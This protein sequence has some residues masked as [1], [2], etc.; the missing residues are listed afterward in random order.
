MGERA[1]FGDAGRLA[2][3]RVGTGA[4]RAGGRTSGCPAHDYRGTLR[5]RRHPAAVPRRTVPEVPAEPGL[6]VEDPASG[7]CG[8]VVAA[9]AREVTL[10]DRH[11]RRRVFPLLPAGVPGR[12]RRGHAG[13]ARAARPAAPARSASGSVA[14]GRAHGAHRAGGADL[15]GGPAR[16]RAGGAGVGPRPAGRGRRR[17]ADARHGRPGRRGRG[18]R[19]RAR[20][21][22]SGCWSTT[23]WPGRRSP[24]AAA[25]SPGPHVLVTGHPYVDVWQ[26]VKPSVVGIRAGRGCRAAPTGRPGS[27][28]RCAGASRPTGP[29]GCSARCAATATWRRR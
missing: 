2:G 16:R 17:G 27:A 29:A 10:E 26:A 28:P 19:A 20:G 23:S 4:P 3:V 5:R 22:G 15:G 24:A 21:G 7:F 13:A 11:G 18:V 9:D 14:G 25:A 6:V 1:T 12:G 8:A